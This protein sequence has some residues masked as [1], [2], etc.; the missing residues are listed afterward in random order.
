MKMKLD[1]LKSLYGKT[2]HPLGR[3]ELLSTMARHMD[4]WDEET[5]EL[6]R[7]ES[8]EAETEAVREFAAKCLSIYSSRRPAAQV[9]PS[10]T[11]PP[12]GPGRNSPGHEER[13]A[14][15]EEGGESRRDDRLERFRSL[16]FEAEDDATRLK[17]SE[18][19]VKAGFLEAREA[20][21]EFLRTNG[22][23]CPP[24]V[25]N[26]L[27][28]C[29]VKLDAQR[30]DF[31]NLI[32]V[33]HEADVATKAH[34]LSLFHLY[35]DDRKDRL[36]L[37]LAAEGDP[38]IRRMALEELLKKGDEGFY[39]FLEEI[40]STP[41]VHMKKDIVSIAAMLDNA[42]MRNLVEKLASDDNP[43]VALAALRHLAM[44]DH[45]CILDRIMELLPEA[46][47]RLLEELSKV[48]TVFE[49]NTGTQSHKQKASLLRA[50]IQRI[51]NGDESAR[52][53]NQ[54]KEMSL[55][56]EEL[57]LKPVATR[58]APGAGAQSGREA[59]QHVAGAP[60]PKKEKKHGASRR[61][62]GGASETRRSKAAAASEA[63]LT[64]SL[65]A[66]LSFLERL[67]KPMKLAVFCIVLFFWI[68]YVKK[69][70][71]MWMEN[72]RMST[73]VQQ[74][75]TIAK[76]IRYYELD[77]KKYT[78]HDISL[79][80][81]KGKLKELKD[82][83][84]GEYE[85]DPVWKRIICHG[86]PRGKHGGGNGRIERP[87]LT[88]EGKLRRPSHYVLYYSPLRP[89][90]LLVQTGEPPYMSISLKADAS[91]AEVLCTS[92]SATPEFPLLPI[93]SPDSSRLLYL[94]GVGPK[95]D[96]MGRI[97]A[98][99]SSEESLESPV[100]LMEIC[101]HGANPCWNTDGRSVLYEI[102]GRQGRRKL[103]AFDLNSRQ[104]L[105]LMPFFEGDQRHAAPLS[106]NV[107]AFVE[108][109]ESA[110]RGRIR[111][112][113]VDWNTPDEFS[114]SG[115]E[116]DWPVRMDRSSIL[117]LSSP[118]GDGIF[119]HLCSCRE[120]GEPKIIYTSRGGISPPIAYNPRLS[121]VAL[122]ERLDPRTTGRGGWRIILLSLKSG[123]PQ[124]VELMHSRLAMVHV[125]WLPPST[126]SASN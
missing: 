66:R 23:L 54:L 21:W 102:Q 76:A 112:F 122:I 116:G 92:T 43:E 105:E 77:G 34:I 4:E 12:P 3:L 121:L 72:A 109:G 115:V 125:V 49:E 96:S 60:A 98:A 42:R 106:P 7:R 70:V 114:P 11:S 120:S 113:K 38:R 25:V 81:D 46:S 8:R 94:S 56:G 78:A 100:P 35:E 89:P 110:G 28:D 82:P 53:V 84:G 13:A 124:V 36:L 18:A 83:W 32:A 17:A 107:V 16:L 97:L 111:Y 15:P 99:A 62:D 51:L 57:L 69:Y 48:L 59:G 1:E 52:N 27:M 101:S 118:L 103:Q 45:G 108:G 64:P 33:L 80:V 39:S 71:L 74:M 73:M 26:R 93:F 37:K 87:E 29:A 55:L 61:E 19:A 10:G 123:Q 75:A 85:I 126:Y 90:R 68:V 47:Q 95:R 119:E 9:D 30:Q 44:K 2:S 104:S 31:T 79:L 58:R 22:R 86:P 67:K 6:F 20:I 5:I 14:S 88:A 24:V 41:A 50:R 117:Y 65:L 40:V 63:S 91:S